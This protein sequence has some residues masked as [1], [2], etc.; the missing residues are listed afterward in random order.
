MKGRGKWGRSLLHVVTFILLVLMFTVNVRVLGPWM[1][2]G[3]SQGEFLC[4]F[5]YSKMLCVR[6]Q[7]FTT[8]RMHA[9]TC[10]FVH[11][12]FDIC[13]CADYAHTNMRHVLNLHGLY[14]YLFTWHLLLLLAIEP[15]VSAQ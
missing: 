7:C 4:L 15:F 8:V 12:I 13:T 1:S 10:T 5:I 6:A 14:F 11:V 3:K 9:R 2:R